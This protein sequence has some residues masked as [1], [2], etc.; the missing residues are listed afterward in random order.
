[1]SSEMTFNNDDDKTT[2]R[3]H[4]VMFSLENVIDDEMG[5]TEE[6]VSKFFLLFI[7]VVSSR[8]YYSFRRS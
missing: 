2:K 3:H 8:L 5:S 4:D 7:P 1:M 6:K